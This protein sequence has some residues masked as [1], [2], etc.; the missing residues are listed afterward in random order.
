MCCIF[1]LLDNTGCTVYFFRVVELDETSHC[2]KRMI[3]ELSGLNVEPPS[4]WLLSGYVYLQTVMLAA[5]TMEC[6]T[7]SWKN[8]MRCM[9]YYVPILKTSPAAIINSVLKYKK[10]TSFQGPI[11]VWAQPLREKHYNVT[12]SLI[13][14]SHTQNYPWLRSGAMGIFRSPRSPETQYTTTDITTKLIEKHAITNNIKYN[15]AGRVDG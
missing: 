5:Q 1:A 11:W 10:I 4:W 13:G 15:A 6:Y 2:F 9:A 3:W 12:P 7:R 8:G 14:R